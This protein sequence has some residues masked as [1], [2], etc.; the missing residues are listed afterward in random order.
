MNDDEKEC[1]DSHGH[2][3]HSTTTHPTTANVKVNTGQLHQGITA[4]G[5]QIAASTFGSGIGYSPNYGTAI[6]YPVTNG[7][8]T[9]PSNPLDYKISSLEKKI[10]MIMDR[11]AIV[12]PMIELH[13][14]YPAL[15]DAYENYKIVEAMCKGDNDGN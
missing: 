12:D 3:W 10:G 14:K 13:E 11:L 8:S 2:G 1:D 7:T 6:A 4:K 5:I 15:K 9:Y